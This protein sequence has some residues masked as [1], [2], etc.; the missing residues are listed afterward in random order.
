[1]SLLEI[2]LVAVALAMD[3]FAVSLAAGATAYAR[4]ARARFRLSFHFGL[5]QCLMPIAGW[6]LGTTVARSVESVDHWVAFGLLAFVGVRMLMAAFREEETAPQRDPSRGAT[7]IMLS[8][9]TS[10]DALAVGLTLAMLEVGIWYASA[11]IGVVTGLLSLV[12][13]RLGNRIGARFGPRMEAVGG[14]ILVVIGA[15]ILFQHLGWG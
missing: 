11:V 15:R 3:A 4:S 6:L 2:L 13:I 8:I 10:I 14:T 7:L 5:F 9:A 12:A 1:M